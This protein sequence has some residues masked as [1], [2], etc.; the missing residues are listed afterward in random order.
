MGWGPLESTPNDVWY[1]YNMLHGDETKIVAQGYAKPNIRILIES[2][3]GEDRHEPT[4]PNIIEGLKWLVTGAQENDHRYFHFSGHG[5]AFETNRAT[6]KIAREIPENPPE[7]T[8]ARKDD[9]EHLAPEADQS[10]KRNERHS[11][12]TIAENE[13]K[14][15]NEGL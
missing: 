3:T 14:Y 10:V 1:I 11:S 8:D 5:D 4:R 15:Y 6:G 12:L 2:M 7:W 13:L 9:I